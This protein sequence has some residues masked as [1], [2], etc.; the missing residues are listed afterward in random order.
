[1]HVVVQVPVF[2]VYA[3]FHYLLKN[4]GDD[5]T[6][7]VFATVLDMMLKKEVLLS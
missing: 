4:G 3:V 2:F 5:E 7:S 6:L 1:M